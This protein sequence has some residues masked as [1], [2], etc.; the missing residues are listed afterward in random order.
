MTRNKLYLILSIALL[1]GYFWA[2]WAILRVD[3]EHSTFTPCIIKHVTGIPCPSRGTTRSVSEI[4][5]G[6]FTKAVLIN[7]LGFV[8][9]AFIILLPFWIIFDVATKN[10]SLYKSY[11]KFE[12]TLKIRWVAILLITLIILNWIWNIYKGL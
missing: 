7:P 5:K 3:A 6:N 10:D 1:A 9:A 11:I 2:A 12:D 4:I 8:I